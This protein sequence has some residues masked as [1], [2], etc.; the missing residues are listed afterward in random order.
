VSLKNWIVDCKL[1]VGDDGFQH[2]A[3][4]TVVFHAVV[5]QNVWYQQ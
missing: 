2:Q 3:T 1:E 4:V 5:L